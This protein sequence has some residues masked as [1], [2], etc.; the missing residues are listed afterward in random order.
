VIDVTENIR[1]A[2][3]RIRALEQE[4]GRPEGAVSLLAASKRQSIAKIREAAAAGL[5]NIGE[6]YLQE[7]LDKKPELAD[8]PQLVWHFIGPIQSNKTRGIAETFDWV[9]SVDRAKIAKRLNDQRPAGKGP[10]NVCVQVKLSA[11]ES[12]SGTKSSEASELCQQIAEL[13]NLTLRGLMAIPAATDDEAAQHRAFSIMA[14]LCQ[15]LQ[16]SH[17]DMDTLSMGM[18]ND[19]AAAIAEGSTMIRLGTALFGPRQF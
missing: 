12:K 16:T 11:E 1:A 3:Q 5:L 9:H 13:P 17:P 14:Y 15:S 7:A 19:Y 4:Y 8:L 2:S 18:S 6:N 10:L